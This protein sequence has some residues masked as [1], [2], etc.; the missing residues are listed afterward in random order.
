MKRQNANLKDFLGLSDKIESET[1]FGISLAHQYRYLVLL[2][3]EADPQIE[4]ARKFYGK[5]TDGSIYY[6]G[7]ELRRHDYPVF[8]KRFQHKLLLILLEAAT[9]ENVTRN[10]VRRAVEY[11]QQS[12]ER[13]LSGNLA[14]SELVI[15]KTLRMPIERYHS[16]FPHVLAAM[17][18]RE[19][20]KTVTPGDLVDYVYVDGE[21]VNPMKRVAPAEIAQTYDTEKYAEMLLDVAESILAVFGFSRTQLGFQRRPRSFLEELQGERGKEVLLELES[22]EGDVKNIQ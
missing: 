15:S 16:L 14:I 9:A 20:K 3:Q 4:A 11:A 22:L 6:R 12:L 5:L 13:V 19:S 21:Q 7:I 17:Q 18:L 2:P 10:Q 1:G 8:L